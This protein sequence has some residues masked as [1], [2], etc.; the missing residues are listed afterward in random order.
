MWYSLNEFEIMTTLRMTEGG[1]VVD[2]VSGEVILFVILVVVGE[3]V[4]IERHVCRR[5][6]QT[7]QLQFF[8]QSQFLNI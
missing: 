8:H 1:G 2:I 5:H 7:Q 4:T 3:E 6:H